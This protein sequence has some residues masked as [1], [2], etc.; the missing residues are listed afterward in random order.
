[1]LLEN[2]GTSTKKKDI[3]N[4]ATVL[5]K[6]YSEEKLYIP[7]FDDIIGV[8]INTY[9]EKIYPNRSSPFYINDEIYD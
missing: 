8:M 4:N 1:V 5:L 3:I 6:K 7:L 2:V 9:I